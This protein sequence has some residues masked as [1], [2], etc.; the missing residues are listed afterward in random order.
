MGI[1][2]LL[3]QSILKSF[4][5]VGSGFER[6]L[7]NRR[8]SIEAAKL[9]KQRQPLID[10]QIQH[11]N[12]LNDKFL[13][14]NPD[15]ISGEGD[16]SKSGRLANQSALAAL[17]KGRT[18]LTGLNPVSYKN[19]VDPSTAHLGDLGY[20]GSVGRQNSLGDIIP[21][22]KFGSV[23]D[24]GAGMTADQSKKSLIDMSGNIL[25]TLA[26]T[27]DPNI[28]KRAQEN[29]ITAARALESTG[30]GRTAAGVAMS[31]T[32][33]GSGGLSDPKNQDLVNSAAKGE[34]Q[35]KSNLLVQQ[36]NREAYGTAASIL[37]RQKKLE[38][39]KYWGAKLDNG[40]ITEADLPKGAVP[41]HNA[42]SKTGGNEI[43]RS[44]RELERF[45]HSLINKSLTPGVTVEDVQAQIK[46]VDDQINQLRQGKTSQI[47][48]LGNTIDNALGAVADGTKSL[49]SGTKQKGF[50]TPEFQSALNIFRQTVKDYQ[51][52]MTD[53]PSI[54]A[55]QTMI[56]IMMKDPAFQAAAAQ[57][58]PND[59]HALEREAVNAILKL[60]ESESPQEDATEVKE[61]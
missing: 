60:S 6:G 21:G 42:P 13:L 35:S 43:E 54:V 38:E 23:G 34:Q 1:H 25:Q 28:M 44:I 31:P 39:G 61:E 40:E 9:R 8:K 27:V 19:S 33:A 53:H 16:I 11:Y 12:N 3:A 18:S 32:I 55:A 2:P 5:S 49:I 14:D 47:P 29:K 45:K 46:Q 7:E 20:T 57:D 4:D 10:A 15:L 26:P 52:G 51:P 50:E 59:P 48:P 36:H 56:N 22:M 30:A 24:S 17:D 58:F 37:D 41:I